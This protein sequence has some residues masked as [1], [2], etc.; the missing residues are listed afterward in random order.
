MQEGRTLR[1]ILEDKLIADIAPDAVSNWNLPGR[2]C[3]DDTLPVLKEKMGWNTVE[4]GFDRPEQ[5]VKA[6]LEHGRAGL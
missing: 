5:P 1:S 3:Y 2:D 4:R 6:P